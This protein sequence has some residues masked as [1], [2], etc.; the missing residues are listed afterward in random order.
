MKDKNIMISEKRMLD[1]FL[2]DELRIKAMHDL[3]NYVLEKREEAKRFA[4]SSGRLELYKRLR[5]PENKISIELSEHAVG[6]NGPFPFFLLRISP[7]EVVSISFDEFP[8][9][10]KVIRGH[11]SRTSSTDEYIVGDHL[12]DRWLDME[13][14]YWCHAD[15]FDVLP[16]PINPYT[17]D[18]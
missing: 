12:V 7:N 15:D 16:S 5:I 14:Y 17:Q 9:A 11:Y 4:K 13:G 6:E 3:D 2:P 10:K 8:T 1:K 18:E